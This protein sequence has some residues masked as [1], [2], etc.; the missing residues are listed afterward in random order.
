MR[1]L[2]WNEETFILE[3]NTKVYVWHCRF[4]PASMSL[5]LSATINRERG[6]FFPLLF[7]WCQ[8]QSSFIHSIAPIIWIIALYHLT[9]CLRYALIFSNQSSRVWSRSLKPLPIFTQ[10]CSFYIPLNTRCYPKLKTAFI[11]RLK[12]RPKKKKVRPRCRW[13]TSFVV[14]TQ[15]S[16]ATWVLV[17]RR[18]NPLPLTNQ[19]WP[20]AFSMPAHWYCYL[21]KFI[22]D[23]WP[24]ET[25]VLPNTP[26]DLKQTAFARPGVWRGNSA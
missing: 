9:P 3:K 5:P 14:D 22:R 20:E 23:W 11:R 26:F 4:C 16:V 13:P 19:L 6:N 17:A 24:V 12:E 10:N 25:W 1:Q 2:W 18:I 8:I 21:L 15:I 7:R